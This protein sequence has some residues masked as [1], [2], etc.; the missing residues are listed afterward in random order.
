MAVKHPKKTK[1]EKQNGFS[2]ME[3]EM[4]VVIEGP[5]RKETWRAYRGWASATYLR[6]L[7]WWKGCPVYLL[8]RSFNF[9]AFSPA[10][11]Y[12]RK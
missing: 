1:C 5:R 4:V 7:G 9:P 8:V 12:R 10:A 3:L 2:G 11:L 6:G